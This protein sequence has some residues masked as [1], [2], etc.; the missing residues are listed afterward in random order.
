MAG[1]P[2]CES[3]NLASARLHHSELIPIASSSASLFLLPLVARCKQSGSPRQATKR[4]TGRPHVV[5][6]C[7]SSS[8]TNWDAVSM[9]GADS[10]PQLNTKPCHHY[11]KSIATTT[12]T[13]AVHWIPRPITHHSC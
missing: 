3:T 8:A 4:E 2:A 1:V 7:T 5:L 9:P 10:I 13:I 12:A 6:H 11:K